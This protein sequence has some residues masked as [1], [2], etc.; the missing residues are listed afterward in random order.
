MENK[1]VAIQKGDGEDTLY[2]KINPTSYEKEQIEKGVVYK[3]IVDT[4]ISHF[5]EK[6]HVENEIHDIIG[7]TNQLTYY[8]YRNEKLIFS[9][10]S[11]NTTIY[12][13]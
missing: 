3:H 7:R 2:F 11:E 6:E 10:T 12:Y 9:M 5:S 8:G 4:I 13:E 1:I